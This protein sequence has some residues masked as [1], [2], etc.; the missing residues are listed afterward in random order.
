MLFFNHFL[1]NGLIVIVF[2]VDI[3][4]FKEDDEWFHSFWM[5]F[6]NLL[7]N[8]TCCWSLSWVQLYSYCW[9][10]I[11]KIS[12]TTVR[13]S[14]LRILS[15]SK[16]RNCKRVQIDCHDLDVMRNSILKSKFWLSLLKLGFQLHF[17]WELKIEVHPT[18]QVW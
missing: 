7:I 14:K 5:V 9:M 1:N 3:K 2:R 13:N 15:N 6:T 4:S 8:N 18:T 17:D 11:C 12:T 10:N 16:I